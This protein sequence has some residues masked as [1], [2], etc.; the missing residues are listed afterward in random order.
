[1]LSVLSI[2]IC[3][4]LCCHG[5]N[6]SNTVQYKCF[7]FMVEDIVLVGIVNEKKNKYK[8]VIRLM[9]VLS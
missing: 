6:G 7:V 1:V 5:N 2:R 3:Q 4:M 9:Y 8:N